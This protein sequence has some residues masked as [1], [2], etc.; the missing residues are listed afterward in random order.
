MWFRVMSTCHLTRLFKFLVYKI[1]SFFWVLVN[2]FRGCPLFKSW[3]EKG[4]WDFKEKI[5]INSIKSG[6][7]PS[8]A[9]RCL[10]VTLLYIFSHVFHKKLKILC[11]SPLI[12]YYYEK[13]LFFLLLWGVLKTKPPHLFHDFTVSNKTH[14]LPRK[15]TLYPPPPTPY[16]TSFLLS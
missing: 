2:R 13:S 12:L 5:P 14:T 4:R 16:P 11:I 8:D 10:I 1:S 7:I 3:A 9:I 15:T 6:A